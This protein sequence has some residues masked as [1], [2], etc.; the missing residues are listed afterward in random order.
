[1]KLCSGLYFYELQ[2]IPITNRE[3]VQ[4]IGLLSLTELILWV[5]ALFTNAN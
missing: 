4:E 5:N 2:I 1:M 3:A